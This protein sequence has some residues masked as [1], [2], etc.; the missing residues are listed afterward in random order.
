VNGGWGMVSGEWCM[1]DG[2]W[3]ETE[4]RK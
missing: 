1:V 3:W 2:V 4:Y